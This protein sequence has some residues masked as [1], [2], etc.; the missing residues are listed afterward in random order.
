VKLWTAH[1]IHITSVYTF[2][3][4]FF[5]NQ[6]K[7]IRFISPHFAPSVTCY[8]E[9]PNLTLCSN[10]HCL[11]IQLLVLLKPRNNKYVHITT[12]CKF[13]YLFY[14][15]TELFVMFISPQLAQSVTC[16]IEIPKFSLF[17]LQQVCTISYLFYWNPV[18]LI[19]FISPQ[20][21]QS[22][23]CSIIT[24][25]CSLCSHLRSLHIQ[26]FV[27]LKPRN[28][29]YVHITRVYTFSY[30]MYWHIKF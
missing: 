26:L 8:I 17:S 28:S 1:Y 23:T 19:I 12:I 7:L 10:H 3:Y 27:L 11:H 20:F 24:P 14:C 18:L 13:I 6:E 21:A 4:L 9:T 25:S 15:N 30:L 2:I 22:V 5:W 29:H 16:T